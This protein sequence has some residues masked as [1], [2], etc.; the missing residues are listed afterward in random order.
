MTMRIELKDYLDND[1]IV[2][3]SAEVIAAKMALD[4]QADAYMRMKE[5]GLKQKDLA[6]AMEI[7]P[8]A[9]SKMLSNE[10]NLRFSTVARMAVALG[11]DVT[12]PQLV[13]LES[14]APVK[15][16]VTLASGTQVSMSISRVEDAPR[17]MKKTERTPTDPID[18]EY[19]ELCNQAKYSESI[20]AGKEDSVTIHDLRMVGVAV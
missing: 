18:D 2:E 11:C 8:A 16:T 1:D 13:P 9:V 12:S 19:R 6:E 3:P 10:S 15:T 20:N 17:S 4:I 5:L 7:T 14:G